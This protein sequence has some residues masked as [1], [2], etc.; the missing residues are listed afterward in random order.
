VRIGG[1]EKNTYRTRAAD[2]LSST[3]AA[4]RD[5]SEANEI[6]QVQDAVAAVGG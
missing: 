1:N 4:E 2:T 3:G 6:H 5:L